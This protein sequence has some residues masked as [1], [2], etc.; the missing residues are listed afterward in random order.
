MALAGDVRDEQLAAEFVMSAEQGF[1]GLDVAFNNAAIMGEL[2]PVTEMALP[3]RENVMSS[4]LQGAFLGAKH[5]IPALLWR[6]PG[7]L[8]FTGSFAGHAAG[9]SGMAAPDEIAQAA[10]FPVSSASSFVTGT[11]LL[12]DVGVSIN[13]A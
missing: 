6:G 1:C 9:L 13:R 2:G 5:Q 8:V 12:V 4:N 3:N 7:A 10:L 11:T